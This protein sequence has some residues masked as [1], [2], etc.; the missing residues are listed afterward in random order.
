MVP[1]SSVINTPSAMLSNTH[2]CIRS[3]SWKRRRSVTSCSTA[4]MSTRPWISSRLIT[5]SHKTSAPSLRRL[6]KIPRQ[7]PVACKLAST[8]RITAVASGSGRALKTLVGWPST[9][10]RAYP[11]IRSAAGF[12][13]TIRPCSSVTTTPSAMCSRIAACV[14]TTSRVCLRSVM[15]SAMPAMR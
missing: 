9:S 14:F 4:T 7:E 3:C 15:S 11:Q 2:A 1:R 6:L 10:L 5:A 13:W 8:S 12:I